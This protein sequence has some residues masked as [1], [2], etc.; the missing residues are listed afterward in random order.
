MCTEAGK[1]SVFLI[2]MK[3]LGM[4]LAYFRKNASMC[5]MIILL[6]EGKHMPNMHK[7]NK[8]VMIYSFWIDIRN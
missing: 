8:Y 4:P 6:N 7:T 3:F 2:C 1:A 5:S